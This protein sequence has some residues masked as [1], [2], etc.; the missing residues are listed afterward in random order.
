MYCMFGG[1]GV[2]VVG[3]LHVD[4]GALMNYAKYRRKTVEGLFSNNM[5]KKKCAKYKFIRGR[6]VTSLLLI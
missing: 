4:A 1:L 3:I 5:K 2:V 6:S